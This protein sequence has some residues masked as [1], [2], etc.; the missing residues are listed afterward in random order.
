MKLKPVVIEGFKKHPVLQN[1]SGELFGRAIS[2]TEWFSIYQPLLF[3]EFSSV[4]ISAG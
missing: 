2:I 3:S 4:N 1:I